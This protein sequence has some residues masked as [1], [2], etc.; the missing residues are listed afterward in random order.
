MSVEHFAPIKIEQCKDIKKELQRVAA[1]HKLEVEELWFEILKT[2]IFIKPS[3]KDDFSEALAGELQQLEE[4]GYY[5][6]KE[7]VLYQAHDVKV[8]LN[9]Y[10]RFFKV[11]V[12]DEASQVEIILDDCFIVLDTEEHYQE[13]FGYIREC[14]ALEGVVLRHLS[15]MYENLKTELRAY[16]KEAKSNRFILYTS[17]TFMPNTEEKPSFLLEE[18]Y[19]P[20]HTI[21]LASQE[22][23]FVKENYYIA[24]ENQIV[25]CV[26]YP[27]QGKD[28]RNLKGFYVEVPKAPSSPTPLGH[29][30]NAFEERDENNA[31]VY[32]SKA[33]QGVKMEKGRLHFR[34][35]F[36]FES[37][38]KSIETPNLLGGLESGIVF[39]IQASGE[40]N[41]AIDCNFI[42]E[43]TTINIKGN[44]GKNV[45][46]VAKEIA[47][48]GQIH[49]ESYVYADKVRITNHK[50]VCYAK[51]FECKYLERGKVYADSAKVEASAGSVVYAK[52]IT[53]E[54]L[55]SDNKLYFS[56]Q[57]VIDEVDGNGNR[58]IFY[59][60]GGRENQEELKIAKK[61]LNQFGL[62]SK[63]IIAQHQS[64]NHLVQNNQAVMEK[65]KNATE[66]IRRSLMQQ[67][68]VKDAYNEF[69]FALK[70]LRILKAQMLEL[71]RLNNECHSKLISIENSMQQASI[72]TKNPFK[73]ENI[74]IYH[75]NYPKVS[76]LTATLSHNE[77]VNVIYEPKENKIKKVFKGAIAK[78]P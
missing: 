4:D 52:E 18:E 20:T 12:N 21:P 75:R 49:P 57:C 64:L 29:D 76:N 22:E 5:E 67:E 58:F 34:Q 35:N 38:I 53:F 9:A 36:A 41:D 65:L 43:A 32:Y 3:A 54:K 63:K 24:K 44:V 11:E 62:K 10:K 16:K 70:R 30:K 42:L 7:L 40:L 61:K 69:M 60:F 59:A 74:V 13:M 31:L 78:K 23:S 50:G 39:E 28:G 6:K 68:S 55:K 19:T 77:N 56:K 48:E 27:K 71:Q 37:G 72:T 45:I 26:S 14:L 46:L 8:K 47:I 73:Q 15:K 2:S 17:S 51:E 25:A 33:L 66:E 1:E